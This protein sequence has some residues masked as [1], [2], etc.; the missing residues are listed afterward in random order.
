MLILG[1][2]KEALDYF[3]CVTKV[4]FLFLLWIKNILKRL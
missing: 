3:P 4:Q 2:V 1:R